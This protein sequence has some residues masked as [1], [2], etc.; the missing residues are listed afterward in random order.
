M[1]AQVCHFSLH[2]ELYFKRTLQRCLCFR[3][4]VFISQTIV[5]LGL[6]SRFRRIDVQTNG[7]PITSHIYV[8]IAQVSSVAVS[9]ASAT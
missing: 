3:A 6:H 8:A 5:L 1:Y 9:M 2:T 7:V 4:T